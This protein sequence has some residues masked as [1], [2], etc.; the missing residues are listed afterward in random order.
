MPDLVEA[1][2]HAVAR[3][4]EVFVETDLVFAI[5]FWWKTRQS[6]STRDLLIQRVGLVPLSPR[7]KGPSGKSVNADKAVFRRA[8]IGPR[9]PM[10]ERKIR[11]KAEHL[12]FARGS[13]IRQSHA[14]RT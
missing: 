1:S 10:R 13:Q 3:L 7:G 4:A 6:N 11:L 12:R 9:D 2:L 14:P 8:F 5:R